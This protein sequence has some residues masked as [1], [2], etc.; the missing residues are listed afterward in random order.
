MDEEFIKT[1][2][3][4]KAF[5]V[6]NNRFHYEGFINRVGEGF[7]YIF[8]RFNNPVALKISDIVSC[9]AKESE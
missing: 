7:V 4:K 3:G 5:I 1:V 2:I 6:L 9:E 8:D